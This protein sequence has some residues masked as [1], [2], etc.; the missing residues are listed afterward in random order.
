MLIL[1]SIFSFFF[2]FYDYYRTCVSGASRRRQGGVKFGAGVMCHV[3]F[4]PPDVY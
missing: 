2:L 4:V 3:L 1:E